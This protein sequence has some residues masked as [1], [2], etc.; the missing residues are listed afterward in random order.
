MEWYL[1]GLDRRP[2]TESMPNVVATSISEAKDA[3]EIRSILRVL[4]KLGYLSSREE[5]V[6]IS[7][8]V[9]RRLVEIHSEENRVVLAQLELLS[10]SVK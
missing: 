8:S 9:S 4:K 7:K 6:V 1:T 3:G 2:D 5:L 10:A